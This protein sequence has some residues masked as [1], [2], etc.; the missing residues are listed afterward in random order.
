M[1]LYSIDSHKWFIF[2]NSAR[3]ISDGREF[4]LHPS[5][6]ECPTR[7]AL[8]SGGTVLDE[9]V[10]IITLPD[11]NIKAQR[12][13]EEAIKLPSAVVTELRDYITC[14][15]TMYRSNAFHN[16]E[17]ASHVSMSVTKLMARIVAPDL[18]PE[19]NGTLKENDYEAHMEKLSSKTNAR[20][21]IT[22]A[23]TLHDHTYGITS[24][25]L[26][27]F[28][29]IFS[30]LIHDVDHNG[31]PN[32][33][34]IK[35]EM[36][37]ARIYRNRSV[38]EQN[39]FDLAWGLL[40]DE[41]FARLRSAIYSTKTELLR[42]RQLTVNSVMATDISDKELKQLRNNRWD[43]AFKKQQNHTPSVSTDPP[44]QARIRMNHRG[45]DTIRDDVNRK[46]TIV[47]EHLIQASDVSHTMQ[48]WH[49]YRK[50][51]ELLFIEMT[52]A[53]RNGR[54]EQDPADFWYK[55]EMG[56]FDYYIIPLAKKLKECG[57]FGKSGD[58]YLNYAERNRSE[59][60][61]KGEL[62]VAEMISN[63]RQ[64]E[65]AGELL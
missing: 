63:L 5:T 7:T 21:S 8:G 51:N 53:Y 14:I 45:H 44:S 57:V 27:H 3:R 22:L 32:T 12:K 59:W 41:R 16:F 29:C 37:I 39:S 2:I 9:V 15:S 34:L 13:D 18:S 50:W 1:G 35:E 58:E 11:F 6:L 4:E 52:M 54:S 20:S 56:F 62:V 36:S 49:I 24:D 55:G 31:V 43:K 61:I 48:H 42:F 19:L 40:F 64:R 33:Q 26:T 30:A 25:P 65:E 38:A 60:E 46:A 23:M 17:H 10:E 28:A 47:I